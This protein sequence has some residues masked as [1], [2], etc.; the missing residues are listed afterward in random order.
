MKEQIQLLAK[1]FNSTRIDND[2]Q[3]EELFKLDDLWHKVYKE[4]RFK[5]GFYEANILAN[6]AIIS[7]T[8]IEQHTN[9]D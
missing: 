9:K 7:N 4:H 3:I 8:I 6:E 1:F 5:K 2:P